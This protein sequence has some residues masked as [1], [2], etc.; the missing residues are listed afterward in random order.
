MASF[1]RVYNPS[2]MLM[3]GSFGFRSPNY[4]SSRE[5]QLFQS[6]VSE[7]VRVLG[8]FNTPQVLPFYS[9]AQQAQRQL[10]DWT[11]TGKLLQLRRGVYAFPPQN[12][13]DGPQRFVVANHMVRPSY[14]SLQSALSYYDLIPEHVAAITSVTTARPQTL[15]NDFGRF[16]YRHVKTDFYYGFR[17][18]AV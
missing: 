15:T 11:R 6:S 17:L 16:I 12:H 10:T 5:H 7:S 3:G 13:V 14:I 1:N 4:A 9:S 8:V 18:W 2:L